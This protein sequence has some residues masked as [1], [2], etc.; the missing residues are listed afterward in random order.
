[1]GLLLCAY[2]GFCCYLQILCIYGVVVSIQ[3]SFFYELV[4]FVFV[5]STQ[6]F[7]MLDNLFVVSIFL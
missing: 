4:Y 7:P 5:F 2:I 3:N 6:A 1:M